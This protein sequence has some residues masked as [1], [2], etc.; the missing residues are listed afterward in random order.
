M[1]YYDYGESKG[2]GKFRPAI[3]IVCFVLG[4]IAVYS[5]IG[6]FAWVI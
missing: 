5:V 4:F 6:F 2:N 3:A 1:R